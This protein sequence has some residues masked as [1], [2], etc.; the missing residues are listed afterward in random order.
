MATFEH[1]ADLHF[2]ASDRFE[3]ILHD[4]LRPEEKA[5]FEPLTRDPDHWGVLRPTG[6]GN[7]RAVD[8]ETALL[9]Y[10]LQDFGTLPAYVLESDEPG[11]VERRIRAMVLDGILEAETRDGVA[12][13][14]LGES[15]GNVPQVDE[16]SMAALRYGAALGLEDA[17]V[18]SVRLYT[19]GGE[20]LSRGLVD[21]L[22]DR[23]RVLEFL[24]LDRGGAVRKV[25]PSAWSAD[26][27]G[28]GSWIFLRRQGSRAPTT[29]KLYVASHLEALPGVLEAVV[30][31]LAAGRAS[32][33]K[34]GGSAI[35]LVRVDKIVAYF[36]SLEALQAFA[37]DLAPQ[38]QP[39]VESSGP[40]HGVPFTADAG[41]EGLLSWGMDPPEGVV[42]LQGTFSD[43]WR[44][45]LTSRLASALVGLREQP[46][47]SH[48][49]R[50][51]V[52]RVRLEGVDVSRWTPTTELWS[53]AP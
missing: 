37:A 13:D 16:R 38:L 1:L 47:P 44:A 12:V 26:S 22:R 52:E 33:M 36:P 51:A 34:V 23:R 41:A 43:S 25:I 20:P 39:L 35:D 42:P 11:R 27:S 30:S 2:R 28:E 32:S 8:R 29:C 14:V 45:W 7:Y 49:V 21:R 10:S 6:A 9:L 53:D 31:S 4:R 24:G 48:R 3:L 5:R 17:E 19:Y 46:D 40:V 15:S 50:S 18:L